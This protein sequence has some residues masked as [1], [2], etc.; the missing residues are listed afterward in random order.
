MVLPPVHLRGVRDLLPGPP[1]QSARLARLLTDGLEAGHK[2]E[3]AREWQEQADRLTRALSDLRAAREW[4]AESLR[5]NPAQ[6]LR[7]PPD[8]IPSPGQDAGRER[9]GH[10]LTDL[11]GL[12][13]EGTRD[14]PALVSP[15]PKVPE[16]T[17]KLLRAVADVCDVHAQLLTE[18]W[19]QADDRG[20]Q[21]MHRARAAHEELKRFLLD[22]QHDREVEATVGALVAR[23]QQLVHDLDRL[24]E[25]D[26]VVPTGPVSG[27][28]SSARGAAEAG[29]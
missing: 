29:T 6:R 20:D 18:P 16:Y 14:A 9:V 4:T 10:H 19:R 1:Q 3:H 8:R 12:L 15:P 11:A 28:E 21:A 7:R 26:P 25:P 27:T 2:A 17:A 13:A 24:E 5:L 23:T 22:P